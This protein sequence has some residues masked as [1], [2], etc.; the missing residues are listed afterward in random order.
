V[1]LRRTI[2]LA[3]A[4]L[5]VLAAACGD[6]DDDVATS[7]TDA[8][9]VSEAAPATSAAGA[10][11]T[12]GAATT[13][14]GAEATTGATTGAT[15][16]GTE[17]GS[18]PTGG[19]GSITVGSADF[20]ESQLLAQIYG[21]AL[22]AAGFD[23]SYEMNIGARE[24]YFD[25]VESGEVDLVPEYTNSLLAFVLRRD[26]PDAVPEATN[27]E[28]QVAAL[29]DALPEGLEV[30]TPSTAE[31]K[32]VIVCTSEAAQEYGLATL[33]DLAGVLD[34]ITLGAPPEFESRSPF[35]LVGFEQI[36][37]AKPVKEFVPL[38]VSGV[39]DALKAGEID[40]GNLFST[41]SVIT[42]EGFVALEDDQTLVPNEAVLP[43]VRSEVVDDTLTATLDEV[44][45]ALDTDV[46][47]ELMVR[48]EVDAAA[49]DVVAG[50]FLDTLS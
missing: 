45:A 40:C 38:D 1:N 15:S 42:T 46:L 20:P 41:M 12:V 43:L 5:L 27:V 9:A 28:E 11:T 29:G 2:P 21:Q 47:K 19:G 14:G 7:D 16:A 26:N 50:E 31:D 22:E 23:V 44:N 4:P 8:A 17:E 18:A 34:Q 3:L 24:I 33:T 48:V 37:G 49:P 32:D 35:G 6:D 10:A 25:A 30:L 39:A 36:L 13:T